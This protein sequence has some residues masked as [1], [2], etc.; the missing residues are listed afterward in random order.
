MLL[1]WLCHASRAWC[2]RVEKS[3]SA[4]IDLHPQLRSSVVCSDIHVLGAAIGAVLRP[5]LQRLSG[6]SP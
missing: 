1:L 6:F 5:S 4:E 3:H 2:S